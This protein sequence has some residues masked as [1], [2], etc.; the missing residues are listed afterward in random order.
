VCNKSF[1]IA[2]E[3]APEENNVFLMLDG[4]ECQY[5]QNKKKDQKKLKKE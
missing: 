2:K 1:V 5:V 4:A 3:E